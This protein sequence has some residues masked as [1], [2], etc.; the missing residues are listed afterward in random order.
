MCVDPRLHRANVVAQVAEHLDATIVPLTMAGPEGQ[1]LSG[2]DAARTFARE[3]F[4]FLC[5]KMY[6]EKVAVVGH[7]NCLGHNVP[8]QKHEEDIISALDVIRSW[9]YAGTIVGLIHDH[10]SDSEWPLRE[11]KRLEPSLK[12]RAA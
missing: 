5:K 12:T 7:C 8:D 6:P 10:E 1:L 9:G 2:S 3:Q 11:L 4:E